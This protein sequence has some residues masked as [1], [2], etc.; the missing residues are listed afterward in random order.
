MTHAD[1][2]PS[3]RA[4]H[5]SLTVTILITAGAC[6][7]MTINGWIGAFG[8]YTAAVLTWC[9]VRLYADHHRTV[10]EHDWARR[11]ALGECPPPL[12]PCCRLVDASDGA[13]HSI[14][15]TDLFHRI[16]TPL[17]TDG[18]PTT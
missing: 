15:C 10:A 2:A 6:Y 17:T 1:R 8:F 3:P 16:V 12:D 4:A 13:V 9:T 11:H 18:H 7:G 5:G 14:R